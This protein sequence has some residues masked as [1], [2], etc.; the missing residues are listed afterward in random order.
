MGFC[1]WPLDSYYAILCLEMDESD[2]PH[3]EN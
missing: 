3:H 1:K 2:Q